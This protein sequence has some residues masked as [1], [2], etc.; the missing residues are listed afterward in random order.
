MLN[1]FHSSSIMQRL[2][3]GE[4]EQGWQGRV[5]EQAVPWSITLEIPSGPEAVLVLCVS[6]W[7]VTLNKTGRGRTEA[8]NGGSDLVKVV[9]RFPFS[10]GEYAFTP[11]WRL[12]G[13]DGVS[14]DSYENIWPLHPEIIHITSDV[15]CIKVGL[16]VE[17]DFSA[18]SPCVLSTAIS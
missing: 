10:V 7:Q 1:L 13:G 5:I 3:E 12:A 17:P 2:I 11:W 8:L 18:I 4:V 15:C 6:L 16:F 14:Y 9:E